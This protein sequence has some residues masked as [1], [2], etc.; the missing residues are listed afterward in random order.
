[1][2]FR[3]SYRWESHIFVFYN[4]FSKCAFISSKFRAF[5]NSS[6]LF[7][8]S[9]CV[10][11]LTGKELGCSSLFLNLSPSL[12]NWGNFGEIPT[13]HRFST[14]Q[15]F[16]STNLLPEFVWKEM[17]EFII[18]QIFQNQTRVCRD[19]ASR[20]VFYLIFI[21]FEFSFSRSSEL[22]P[23]GQSCLRQWQIDKWKMSLPPWYFW[24][25]LHY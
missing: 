13:F 1:M 24:R 14:R 19:E 4:C 23:H 10:N 11:M 5:K 12:A 7:L 21:L 9:T 22:R 2:I 25:E 8:I 17:I 15:R 16:K 20:F 6:S 18:S 3:V